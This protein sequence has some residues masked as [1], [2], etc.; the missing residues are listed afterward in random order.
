[1]K[2]GQTTPYCLKA[3]PI[4]QE[5]ITSLTFIPE[6]EYL[7]HRKK[8]DESNSIQTGIPPAGAAMLQSRGSVQLTAVFAGTVRI[9]TLQAPV[10]D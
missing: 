5:Y 3:V 6:E 9:V 4:I 10:A 7:V 1:M 8:C 2:E